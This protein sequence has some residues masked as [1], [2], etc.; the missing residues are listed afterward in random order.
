MRLV[1]WTDDNGYHHQSLLRDE[2]NDGEAIYGIPLDPPSLAEMTG[3]PEEVKRDLHNELVARGLF[4]WADVLAQARQDGVTGAVKR[5][6]SQHDLSEQT[7]H[8]VR[9]ALL[10][11]YR[12]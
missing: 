4:T 3:I 1:Q 5:V 12:R 2:D 7:V 6:A 9:R 8:D 10:T 11:E